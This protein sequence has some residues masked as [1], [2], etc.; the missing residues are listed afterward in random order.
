MSNTLVDPDF[1][2]RLDV[3]YSDVFARE[4]GWEYEDMEEPLEDLTSFFRH[5]PGIRVL[6]VGCGWAR[7]VYRFISH[8]LDYVGIDHSVEMINAACETCPNER[9]ELM[10]YRYLTFKPESFDGLWCCCSFSG[11]PKHNMP[12]VLQG[13]KEVL[14][15]GGAMMVT[16]PAVYRSHEQMIKDENGDPLLYHS[17]Y[18]LRELT[19]LLESTGF[20]TIETNPQWQHGAMSVLVQKP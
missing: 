11:E 17:H 2:E 6:D 5:L 8:G 18:E 1:A 14:V 4:R 7:Y 13:L 10:S 19:E 16:M 9:F 20:T 15:P 3:T 12:T